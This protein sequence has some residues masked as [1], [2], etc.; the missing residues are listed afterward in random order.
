MPRVVDASGNSANIEGI[1]SGT[2]IESSITVGNTTTV[3]SSVK[4]S[5]GL[6]I[7]VNDSNEVIYLG[8]GEAAVMNEGPRLNASGGNF[9]FSEPNG[10]LTSAVINAI[11]SSGS[12]VLT[13][14][15]SA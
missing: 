14:T 10:N 4:P 6:L 15:E 3:V 1:M 9:T 12:K 2:M 13:V 8:I 5:R 7:L 11:C